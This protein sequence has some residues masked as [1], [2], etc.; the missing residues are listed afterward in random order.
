MTYA[1][2]SAKWKAAQNYCKEKGI[3]FKILTEEDLF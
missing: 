2:N 1:V 3:K